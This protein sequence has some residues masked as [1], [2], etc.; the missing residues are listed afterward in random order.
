M[1]IGDMV[2]PSSKLANQQDFKWLDKG[3]RGVV[4]GGPFGRNG[5]LQVLWFADEDNTR[6]WVMQRHWLK[7]AS[8]EKGKR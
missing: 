7:Y 5:A 6:K 3:S 1:K 8:N 2:Q 4:V